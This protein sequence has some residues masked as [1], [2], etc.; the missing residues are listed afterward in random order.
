MRRLGNSTS[1]TFVQ[2]CWLNKTID[3]IIYIILLNG[4]S[5]YASQFINLKTQI[6]LYFVRLKKNIFSTFSN[7]IAYFL[8]FIQAEQNCTPTSN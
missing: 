3:K 5:E 2:M 6:L 4:F 1:S 8:V 7:S